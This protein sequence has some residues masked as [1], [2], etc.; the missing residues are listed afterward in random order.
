MSDNIKCPSCD[1]TN[2][3]SER[4]M[5]IHHYQTHDESLANTETECNNCSST[6]EILKCRIENGKG[7]YCSKE[8]K[9]EAERHDI[10]VLCDWCGESMTRQKGRLQ[11]LM[12][13]G[14]KCRAEY[15]KDNCRVRKECLCC[16]SEFEVVESLLKYD[17]RDYCSRE[18]FSNDHTYTRECGNCGD[19]VEVKES[20]NKK[21][22]IFCSLDCLHE[23]YTEENHPRWEGGRQYYGPNW[24][25]IR[26]RILERD[27]HQCQNCGSGDELHIHHIELLSS[28]DGYKEAN[29]GNNLVTLCAGCHASVEWGDME[30]K[31]DV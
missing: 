24:K 5:K 22:D 10:E 26:Q 15:Q 14:N 7:K 30:V 17:P 16:G 28:F 4:G 8:C 2:F 19:N 27:D 18:C 9:D 25:E 11:D 3:P 21:E 6:F 23:N 1:R 31:I 12:F 29:K 13:C 20:R